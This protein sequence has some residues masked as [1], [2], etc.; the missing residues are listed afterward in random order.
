MAPGS[1]ARGWRLL[2]LAALAAAPAFALRFGALTLPLPAATAAY[3]LAVVG[4]AFV[5]TWACEAAEKD[6]SAALAVALLA[7]VAVLPEYA[8]DMYFAWTAGHRPEYTAYATANMTGANRLLIGLGW[9][10]IVVTLWLTTRKTLLEIGRSRALELS[11]LSAA[12][13]YSFIL[14]IKG[15]LAPYDSV[16]LIGLFVGYIWLAARTRRG[17]EAPLL[18]GPAASI[19]GLPRTRRRLALA[20]MFGYAAAVIALAAEAFAGGLVETGARLGIDR[21]LLVQWVAP[22]ASEAPEFIAAI[23]LTLRGRAATGMSALLSSKLNQWTLL[24]GGIPLAYSLSRGGLHALPL[25]G[26]Q[27]EE[28][29]LTAA[30][31]ALAVAMLVSLSISL[32]E[33]AVLAG[34]FLVQALIQDEATR[35]LFAGL[36]LVLAAAILWRQRQDV[37]CLWRWW[38]AGRP[39]EELTPEPA[40]SAGAGLRHPP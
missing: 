27:A 11:F 10:A 38:R 35:R 14:P 20:A 16:V 24:I 6:I 8:V 37:V 25:D 23:L 13:L 5:L 33:A 12:T 19:G 4:A 7:L 30:Q 34:L 17:G 3:G 32:K 29:L 26:R 31:S 2:L 1:S 15:S 36:Y 39:S 21:F 18:I 9:P 40:A 28:L 22:I